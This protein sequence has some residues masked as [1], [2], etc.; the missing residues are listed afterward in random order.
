MKADR[1]QVV[2]V[3]SEE[4]EL[5]EILDDLLDEA[6]LRERIRKLD[7]DDESNLITLEELDKKFGITEED[8]EKVGDVR[9][10]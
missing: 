3:D 9:F 6:V 8:L 5:R 10:E 1:N 4:E 7:L 2:E